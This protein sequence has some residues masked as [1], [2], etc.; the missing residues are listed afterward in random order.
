MQ[1]RY[2]LVWLCPTL[3][4]IHS[5]WAISTFGKLQKP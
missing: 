3:S 5:C 4:N 2:D 1:P